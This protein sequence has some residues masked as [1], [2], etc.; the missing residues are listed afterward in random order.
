MT[1]GWRG[2]CNSAMCMAL[3]I[4]CALLSAQLSVRLRLPLQ[5]R[6][7]A[8]ELATLQ[9]HARRP[10]WQNR[11]MAP[12]LLWLVRE[13]APANLGSAQ[14][15]AVTRFLEAAISFL[16]IYA[17]VLRLTGSRLRALVVVFLLTYAYVWTPLTLAYEM[18]SD[19]F[20]LM[21]T[22]AFA[23]LALSRRFIVLAFTAVVA[24]ANRESAAFGGLIWLGV[25]SMRYPWRLSYWHKFLPGVICIALAAAVVIGLRY[26]LGGGQRLRQFLGIQV[27]INYWHRLLSPFGSMPGLLATGLVFVL[28]LRNLPKPWVAEQKG[29]L[30]AAIVCAAVTLTFGVLFELRILLPCWAILSVLAVIGSR[31]LDD[32]QWLATLTGIRKA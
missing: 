23:A 28:V 15:W 29:L 5:D 10:E 32:R 3:V 9:G 27:T 11:V 16:A 22:V 21:F 31:E 4:S 8:D 17:I 30:A 12:A 13:E 24:A 26:G 7:F 1:N 19:F 20:D 25:A 6:V 18:S 14:V 2:L